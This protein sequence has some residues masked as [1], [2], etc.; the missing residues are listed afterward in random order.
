MESVLTKYQKKTFIKRQ[1][2]NG[3]RYWI[4]LQIRYDDECGNKHNSFAMTADIMD[5]RQY[6]GGCQHEEIKKHFPEYVKYIKWHFMNSDG[7][8]HYLANTLYLAGDKDYYGRRAGEPSSFSLYIKFGSFPITYKVKEKLANHI[9]EGKSREI[10][11]IKYKKDKDTGGYDFT[12]KYTWKGFCEKWYECPFDTLREA[13]ELTQALDGYGYDDDYKIISV[14]TAWSKGKEPE[15][16]SARSTA[17]WPDATIEQL[18]DKSA[19]EA[20]LPQLIK[21]FKSDLEEL[22]FTY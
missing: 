16:E 12:P 20:R 4:E 11:K 5:G 14:P 8:M 19:L 17:I 6:S 15:L 3:K 7:P 10:V 21:D 2:K 13:E 18:Q 1:S 22:G 9:R